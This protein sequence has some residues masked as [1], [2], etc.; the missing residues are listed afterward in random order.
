MKE[1]PNFD[2][3]I[4]PKLGNPTLQAKLIYQPIQLI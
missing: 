2:Q 1:S 3:F 4:I